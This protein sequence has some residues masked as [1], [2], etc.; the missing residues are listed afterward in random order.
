MK[1]DQNKTGMQMS[2]DASL[3]RGEA[4]RRDLAS[5]LNRY[6]MENASNTPDFLLA[7]YLI[8]CLRALDKTISTRAKWYGHH[9]SPN[10]TKPQL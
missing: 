8:D 10:M 3:T 7:D 6:S 9:D 5:L 2:M 4:F 1:D